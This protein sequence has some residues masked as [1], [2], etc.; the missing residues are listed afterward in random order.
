MNFI[1]EKVICF[2]LLKMFLYV[3]MKC[4]IFSDFFICQIHKVNKDNIDIFIMIS[5]YINTK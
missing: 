2:S 5:Y 3:S 1:H 4:M